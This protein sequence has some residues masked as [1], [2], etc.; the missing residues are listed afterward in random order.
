M[1]LVHRVIDGV[2]KEIILLAYG[3][4]DKV[5]SSSTL[6]R[7]TAAA[8]KAL[9]SSFEN[10]QL[11]VIQIDHITVLSFSFTLHDVIKSTSR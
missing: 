9:N 1:Q 8:T 2:V 5:N 6:V 11:A 3:V 4:E 10:Q 7:S